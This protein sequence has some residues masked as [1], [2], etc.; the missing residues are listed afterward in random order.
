MQD[1]TVRDR[2]WNVIS[3]R[4][5]AR[6]RTKFLAAVALLSLVATFASLPARAGNKKCQIGK[7]ADLPITMN[8]LRP[9]IP[10]KI[11]GQEAKF[12]L[13][14]G[15]FY[16]MISSATASEYKLKLSP[17]PFGLTVRGVGG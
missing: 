14:S 17:G 10:A 4:P 8:S 5:A 15:A 6:S 1:R 11:N 9:L 2:T 12:I 7:V 13:D 3:Q 16:S